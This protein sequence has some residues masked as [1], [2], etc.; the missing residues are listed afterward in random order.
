MIKFFCIFVKFSYNDFIKKLKESKKAYKK[1]KS[2][3]TYFLYAYLNIMSIITKKEDIAKYFYLHFYLNGTGAEFLDFD[4]PLPTYQKHSNRGYYIAWALNGYFGTKENMQFLKDIQ[5]RFLDTFSEN[6]AEIVPFRPNFKNLSNTKVFFNSYELKEFS[7]KL[8]SIKK[9]RNFDLSMTNYEDNVFWQIKVYAEMR[10]SKN[11]IVSYEEL[12][13]FA[14]NI[15]MEEVKDFSTLRSKCRNIWHWYMLRDFEPFKRRK[16]TRTPEEIKLTRQEKAKE[17]SKKKYEINKGKIEIAIKSL[18]EQN[19][20]LKPNKK[21][22]IS[23]IAKLTELSRPTVIKHI[24][25]M[26]I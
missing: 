10:I 15:C 23:A 25:N 24:E 2:L 4:L 5:L 16:S 21:P 7:T 17:N 19:K 9:I 13:D 3:A 1:S 6:R 18:K 14:E 22:N 8:N 26:S 20:L 12:I 11:G